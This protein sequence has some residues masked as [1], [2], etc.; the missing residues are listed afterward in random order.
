MRT[1]NLETFIR[2]ARTGSFHAAAEQ[3]NTSQP[4][5]SA[6]IKTLEDEL[7]VKLFM[8]DKSGTR[9]TPR[10]MQTLPYAEKVLAVAQEM[11]QQ[12]QLDTPEQGVIRIGI[13]DTLANLWLTQMLQRWGEQFPL[14]EFEISVDVSTVLNRQ[15]NDLQLDLALMVQEAPSAGLITEPLCSYAQQWVAAPSLIPAQGSKAQSDQHPALSFPVLSFPRNTRPWFYL[16][17]LFSQLGDDRPQL[18]T[19]SSV[20]SLLGLA[21]QGVG[22][23][24]LP[25]PLL[26][27]SLSHG[28]LHKLSVPQQPPALDF[29][30]SWRL[31]DDRLLP[32]LLAKTARD[33]TNKN[34]K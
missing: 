2:V 10:G 26:Q 25:E 19:C 20:S 4:A 7:G 14:L 13:T 1:R 24:L 6:R 8:R 23:A 16:Q 15:L 28:K 27:Q 18:H 12:L 32:R 3:L 31:D 22:I 29:C 34:N 21:E 33:I 5:V 11:K 30:C 9:L 17:Q